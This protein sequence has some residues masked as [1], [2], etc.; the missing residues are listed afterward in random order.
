M[1]TKSLRLSFQQQIQAAFP[2]MMFG[3]MASGAMRGFSSPYLNSYLAERGF[4][5]TLIGSLVSVAALIELIAIPFLSAQAN[6]HRAHRLLYRVVHLSYGL[7][8]LAMI[9][10]PN[11]AV[12]IAAMLVANV[13][14]KS[15]FVYSMQL[16]FTRLEQVQRSLFGWVRSASASGFML[17]NLFAPLIFG[18]GHYVGLFGASFLAGLVSFGTSHALPQSMQDKPDSGQPVKRT[19]KLYPVLAAEFFMTMGIR[20]AFTFWLLFFQNDLGVPPNLIPLIVTFSALLE[21]PFFILLERPLKQGQA[22]FTYMLGGALFGIIWVLTGFAPNVWWLIL[23]LIPRGLAFAMWNLSSLV[24]INQISHPRNVSSN[25]AIA[26]V[27]VPSVAILVSGA[28]MGWLYDHYPPQLF[29]AVCCLFLFI[30]S[31]IML[32]CNKMFRAAPVPPAVSDPA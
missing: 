2:L 24:L 4:T 30:G 13:S 6:R 11:P 23:I 31:G 20:N 28:P 10:W 3:I 25:Q 9:L 27:T 8:C 1:T 21:I 26:Q 22:W 12:L 17:S 14:M 15:T 7:A 16:S 5:G 19:Y 18:V 32:A 29:F